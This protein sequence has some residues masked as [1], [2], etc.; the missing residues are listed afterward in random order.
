M[1]AIKTYCTLHAEGEHCRKG[2]ILYMTFAQYS[3]YMCMYVCMFVCMCLHYSVYV[4]MHMQS[5]SSA[6]TA[7]GDIAQ[8][9]EFKRNHSHL[10]HN[11]QNCTHTHKACKCAFEFCMCTCVCVRVHVQCVG[12]CV[13]LCF[14]VYTLVLCILYLYP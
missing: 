10:L 5:R 4:C 7:P 2:I 13:W 11:T 1:Q 3:L 12:V 14:L 8:Y 9:R 6:S